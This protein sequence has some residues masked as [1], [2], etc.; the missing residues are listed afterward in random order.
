MTSLI[1]TGVEIDVAKHFYGELL[2]RL[3]RRRAIGM[4][5]TCFHDFVLF[6]IIFIIY[7]HRYNDIDSRDTC[8]ADEHL[9]Q[10]VSLILVD[11]VCIYWLVRT[12][13]V[14]VVEVAARGIRISVH[15]A[16][17][18]IPGIRRAVLIY[19]FFFIRCTSVYSC[20]YT[21]LISHTRV[22]A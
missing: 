12:R 19:Q 10:R 9:K 2:E 11:T 22:T 17:N 7:Y 20:T 18:F 4:Y 8:R 13:V 21:A 1:S 15:A 5:A 3:S 6:L 16:P 14:T